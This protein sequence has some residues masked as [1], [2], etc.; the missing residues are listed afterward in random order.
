MFLSEFTNIAPTSILVDGSLAATPL[1]TPFVNI[2]PG[3]WIGLYYCQVSYALNS[4]IT[5]TWPTGINYG[6]LAVELDNVLPGTWLDGS[7]Q[8]NPNAH[9]YATPIPAGLAARMVIDAGAGFGFPSLINFTAGQTIAAFVNTFGAAW[10]AWVDSEAAITLTGFSAINLVDFGFGVDD[11][12][13]DVIWR[14]RK[15]VLEA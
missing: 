6:I 5:V 3:T 2:P 10:I 8:T 7:N 15:D 9:N 1:L 12:S 11:A 13:Q 14:K 4:T